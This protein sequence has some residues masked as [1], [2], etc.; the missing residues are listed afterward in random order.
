MHDV[1]SV[2]KFIATFIATFIAHLSKFSQLFNIIVR[3]LADIL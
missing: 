3:T 1:D 2:A